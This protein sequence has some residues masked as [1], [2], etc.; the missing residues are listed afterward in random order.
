MSQFFYTAIFRPTT[1]EIL[2]PEH[3]EA[4]TERDKRAKQLEAEARRLSQKHDEDGMPAPDAWLCYSGADPVEAELVRM[5][6]KPT[7]SEEV[8]EADDKE[9]AIAKWKAYAERMASDAAKAALKTTS[10]LTAPELDDSELWDH[11]DPA[12]PI[13]VRPGRELPAWALAQH[14]VEAAEL[15]VRDAQDGVDAAQKRADEIIA[16]VFSTAPDRPAAV[17]EHAE[18]EKKTLI[19]GAPGADARVS[20]DDRRQAVAA[21]TEVD[22]QKARLYRA[23][24]ELKA[25]QNALAPLMTAM[26]E[27]ALQAEKDSAKEAQRH[28]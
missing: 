9:T 16:R 18:W 12:N 24:E 10:V 27:D 13:V 25:R 6:A 22:H 8:T 20:Y 5:A 28:A 15:A 7:K 1:G 23:E 14:A 19:A 2:Y 26:K 4:R 3:F 17:A 11:S 21:Q